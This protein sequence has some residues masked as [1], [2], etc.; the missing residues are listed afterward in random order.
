MKPYFYEIGLS[1]K[2]ISA[3][4][5]L[6]FECPTSVQ[7][8]SIPYLLTSNRDCIVL[9]K[10]GTGKTAAF[11]FTLLQ[12]IVF[13]YKRAQALVLCPTRELCLQIFKYLQLFSK[14]LPKVKITAVYGGGSIDKQINSLEKGSQI[15]VSTPGRLVDFIF[16][17]NFK[18]LSI[19]CFV[20]D[21]AD[22]MLNMGFKDEL[23]TIVSNLPKNSQTFLFSATM[24]K[25]IIASDYLTYPFQINTGKQLRIGCSDN[26]R[27][28]YYM[29]SNK[30]RYLA[31]KR[32]ADIN[33]DIY[34]IVFCRTQQETKEVSDLLIKENYNAD[35]IYGELSQTQRDSVMNRF[36]ARKLK[37]LVATDIASRGLDVNNITHVINYNLPND[38]ETYVHRS[39]RTGRAG[40]HGISICIIHSKSQ[41]NRLRDLELEIGKK[42]EYASVPTG[43]EICKKQIFH[44]IERITHVIVDH[45]SIESYFPLL[46]EYFS[47][48]DIE[49]LIKRF[50][51]YECERFLNY[52]KYAKNL[53][54]FLEEKSFKQTKHY[55][56]SKLSMNFGRKYG[57]KKNQVIG[58]IATLSRNI[59]IRNIEILPKNAVFEVDSAFY[60]KLINVLQQMV[61]Q[62]TPSRKF[63]NLYYGR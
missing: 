63:T 55:Y 53:N 47:I 3:L 16:S 11:V 22:E 36:R 26:V 25:G 44:L 45:S 15:I 2:I 33:P 41:I 5:D 59:E 34:G 18:L 32:I 43:Y 39:G 10:T 54:L 31:I 4:E 61:Y 19:R 37:L 40:N 57:I 60:T 42:I 51:F 7:K 46:L 21:E 48:F 20:L 24:Q 12:K 30:N 56:F 58:M 14:T 1:T 28:V 27:H 49:E 6:G 50:T 13:S 62:R 17:K 9:A 23:D 29:V 8:K 38:N 52:Y 35:A